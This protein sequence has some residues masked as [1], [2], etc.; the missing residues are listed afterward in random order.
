M[1]RTVPF[2]SAPFSAM[3]IS[4]GPSASAGTRTTACRGDSARTGTSAPRIDALVFSA[5]P[6]NGPWISSGRP[7]C[8][9]SG[10]RTPDGTAGSGS[11]RAGSGAL[12]TTFPL[13]SNSTFDGAAGQL[14]DEDARDACSRHSRKRAQRE[15]AAVHR[16]G[17]L[18][19]RIRRSCSR[20]RRPSPPDPRRPCPRCDRPPSCRRGARPLTFPCG[21]VK[22]TA[23]T[24]SRTM[25]AADGACARSMHGAAV[26][27]R[28][29]ALRMGILLANAGGTNLSSEHSAEWLRRR[30]ATCSAW[31]AYFVPLE[32]RDW[33]RL[34]RACGRERVGAPLR[35]PTR[36]HTFTTS[37]R[38]SS[39]TRYA[40]QAVPQAPLGS[41]R[42]C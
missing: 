10:R 14:V 13:L 34:R 12:A 23:V 15:R 3:E 41:G 20:R 9:S 7:A 39:G 2:V 26:R 29:A 42:F 6:S 22:V 5:L 18:R 33:Y 16:D 32:R 36:A 19:Q 1:T 8:A 4:V 31:E 35:C 24:P 40:P 27:I 21:V 28:S 25:V 17:I 11:G 37:T 30:G 38:L